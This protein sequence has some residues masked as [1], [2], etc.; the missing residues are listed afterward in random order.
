[1][2]ERK[3][4]KKKKRKHS[5]RSDSRSVSRSPV[6]SRSRKRKTR[7]KDRSSKTKKKKHGRNH[8]EKKESDKEKTS[9]LDSEKGC[10]DD[11]LD[12]KSCLPNQ[13]I[14]KNGTKNVLDKGVIDTN[15][16]C[17]FTKP[18]ICMN[19][20]GRIIF[21]K[22]EDIPTR[23]DSPN[24]LENGNSHHLNDKDE[25][26]KKENTPTRLKFEINIP[27]K[28]ISLPTQTQPTF[29][30]LSNRLGPTVNFNNRKL[31]INHNIKNP[32]LEPREGETK[33][34]N[35]EIKPKETNTIQI[36]VDETEDVVYLKSSKSKSRSSDIK[37]SRSRSY[38]YSRSRSRSY[39]YSSYSRSRS[40]S[41]SFSRSRSRSYSSASSRSRSR[42]PSIQRR[43][44]SPSFLDKRR[45][46]R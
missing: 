39:S 35:K 26:N 40:R 42:S 41:W 32:L 11:Q 20:K 45:I 13:E 43:R 9:K 36:D 22:I 30:E 14:I 7:S 27:Q 31:G 15:G 29:A 5:L 34:E 46:T 37:R 12:P 21:S 1:L 33:K 19:E 18:E 3:S 17:D 10:L 16:K 28:K 6:G 38:S 23:P 2:K 25:C 44:G 8:D 4:R 24:L